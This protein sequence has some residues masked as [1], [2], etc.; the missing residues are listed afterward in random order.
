MLGSKKASSTA[1]IPALGSRRLPHQM[2]D[3]LTAATERVTVQSVV[4]PTTFSS[5][6][7]Q[8]GVLENLQV[9]RKA[10]LGG[11]E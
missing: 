6:V 3:E 4:H 5:V 11:I 7:Y 8:P 1:P 2:F 9:E 10:R